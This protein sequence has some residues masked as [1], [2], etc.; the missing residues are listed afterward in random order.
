MSVSFIIFGL[1]RLHGELPPLCRYLS[2]S[3]A[4]FVR[5]KLSRRAASVL[6]SFIIFGLIRLHGELSRPASVSV[7]FLVVRLIRQGKALKAG[8]LCVGIF[9]CRSPHSSGQSSQGGPRST[10]FLGLYIY[11]LG[12]V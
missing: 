8:R 10:A 9:H 4:S 5:A 1:I 2:L 12:S 7:S 3:F 6:V 11:H